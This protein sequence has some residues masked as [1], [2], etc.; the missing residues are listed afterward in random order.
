M[1]Y[2]FSNVHSSKIS[3][4][5]ETIGMDQSNMTI[6]NSTVPIH[7]PNMSHPKRKNN[8]HSAP[9]GNLQTDRLTLGDEAK[10]VSFFV[11]KTF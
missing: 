9:H 3:F 2:L 1:K 11:H 8:R 5:Q 7:P 6:L 4:F 10:M